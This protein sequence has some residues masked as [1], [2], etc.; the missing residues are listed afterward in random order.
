MADTESKIASHTSNTSDLRPFAGRPQ[1]P[2][3][4]QL[5]P[6]LLSTIEAQSHLDGDIFQCQTCL[7]WIHW[8]LSEPGLASSRLPKNIM[9]IYLEISKEENPP[10]DY[11]TVCMLKSIYMRASYR[12]Q[13]GDV[14][15][16]LESFNSVVSWMRERESKLLSQ[17][18]LVLWSEQVLAQ[19]A[20]T[21]SEGLDMKS[22]GVERRIETALQGFR[23]WAIFSARSNETAGD[24]Y[25]RVR[26]AK[27]KVDMWRAYYLFL[28]KL[29]QHDI[30]HPAPRE[31]HTRLPQSAE[32]RRVE[33]IYE[34]ELLRVT[35][36]PKAQESN[37]IIENW[38]EQVIQNW[39][40]LCGRFW[41]ETELGE[42]GR[43]AVGRNVLDVLYRAA[44]KT[45][46]SA[47]I[48]RRLFQVHKSLADFSLAYKAL[49]SY[50]EL[51]T[52]AKTK[53]QKSHEKSANVDGDDNV[54]RTV[55]EAIEGLCTFGRKD[56]AEQAFN[57]ARKLEEWTKDYPSRGRDAQ[58]NGLT[59]SEPGTRDIQ[60]TTAD[61]RT[62]EITYRAI[63]LG[64]AFWAMWTPVSER[65]VTY[66]SEALASF[67]QALLLP[68]HVPPSLQTAYAQ[69]LLFAET[70]DLKS[71]IDCVKRALSSSTAW[72]T[73]QDYGRPRSMVRL[74]HLLALLLSARQDFST[75]YQMCGA[76]FDQFSDSGILFRDRTASAN[77]ESTAN[78]D[79]VSLND[80]I[81]GP[82]D[83]MDEREREDIIEIKM[84][85]LA[86]IELAEGPDEAVNCSNEL[87]SLFSRLFGHLDVEKDERP[88]SKEGGP[89]KSSAGTIKSLRGSI[90]GWR[91]HEPLFSNQRQDADA[92]P[93]LPENHIAR[94][95]TNN[96]ETPTIRVTDEDRKT[97]KQQ[98]HSFRVPHIHN[99]G[100]S[101]SHKL[102]KREGPKGS[103]I[104]RRSRSAAARP[105]SGVSS[106]M[107]SSE[108]G[109]GAIPRSASAI[110]VGWNATSHRNRNMPVERTSAEGN[111]TANGPPL[112]THNQAPDAKVPLP[113][114]AHNTDLTKMP[115]PPGHEKQP[116]QQD[117][118]LPILHP[119][120][121]STQPPPRSPRAAEQI[122]AH[123]ILAKVWLLVA[124]LYRRA[125]LFDDSLEA[126][127]E[128]SRSASK[129]ESLVAARESSAAA[130]AAP[131]WTGG[132]S[133]NEVWADVY[134]ER[135]NLASA[136]GMPHEAVH[137][138][139]EA[140]IHSLDHPRAT[141]GLSNILLD[142]YE[143]KI[144]SE[145]PQPGLDV[146]E[147]EKLKLSRNTTGKMK[148]GLLPEFGAADP[149][150]GDGL[151][152]TPENLNRLAARD[153]AYGLLSNLTKL[154]SS[155]DDSEAWYTLAR[156]H[157]C[158]GQIEKAREVL[159]WCVEL[160]DKRP[161]RH[162]RNIG[163]GPYV[164]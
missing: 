85:E 44:T 102:H 34:S 150:A 125:S 84:T 108:N 1:I 38:V 69:A 51:V 126:Y 39:K 115:P 148:N 101:P 131:A 35:R 30:D 124:G 10:L 116:P 147:S 59:Q 26:P 40:F 23:H 135:A 8:L 161:V 61:A 153:R 138:F 106:Q 107:Q 109:H 163:T 98:S 74:W 57:L 60:M 146:E 37:R 42:G 75:A 81:S 103:I 33:S 93:S 14:S 16:S 28:S 162:W 43:N 140:L 80:G 32:L 99:H 72:S 31:N 141:V 41:P 50:L 27:Q 76:A 105:T 91:R 128:A 129:I 136:K 152:E 94:H 9:A 122:H 55:S 5:I 52:R 36:F 96:T 78:E 11:T 17:S 67:K 100:D 12:Q 164:L 56:E 104:R 25:G 58:A 48:L 45:F 127:D 7:A 121:T 149:R 151:G 13:E 132:R 117:V 97:E 83:G 71:A 46:H 89:P 144:P 54:L 73:G 2:E 68:C 160:E 112:L 70:R 145:P 77:E 88:M 119:S 118:R 15:G 120:N 62:L 111:L 3:L 87:L 123:G 130:F 113:P 92:V 63:G 22:L 24:E 66:Q 155:W 20:I 154:G 29:L 158:S 134:A 143:Q 159:W 18:Q 110:G 137:Y 133:S 64:K 156:A 86:L 90:F 142:I 6:P 79:K 4:A 21:A 53:A 19:M 82:A 65:R 47:L 49:Y 114:V 157:E 95:S 139:E